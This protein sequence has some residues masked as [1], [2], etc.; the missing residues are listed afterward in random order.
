MTRIGD[1]ARPIVEAALAR[2]ARR[3]E[4]VSGLAS[5]AE[6]AFRRA[7]HPEEDFYAPPGAGWSP[8]RRAARERFRRA[9]ALATQARDRSA[10]LA[11]DL[12]GLDP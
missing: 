5:A 8:E 10:R 6:L 11:A 2:A 9:H 1:N 12:A 4:T 3:A 7:Q